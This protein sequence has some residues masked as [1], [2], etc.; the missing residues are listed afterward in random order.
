MWAPSPS[1]GM[2]QSNL[3]SGR[4]ALVFVAILAVSLAVAEMD[5]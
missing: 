3:G 1:I 2:N 5:R 4:G